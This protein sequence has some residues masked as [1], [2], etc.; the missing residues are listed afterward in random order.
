M[1]RFYI[2]PAATRTL[3]YCK[4]SAVLQRRI[5]RPM[6]YS[7]PIHGGLIVR[8][9]GAGERLLFFDTSF[10]RDLCLSDSGRAYDIQANISTSHEFKLH[11][12]AR[13]CLVLMNPNYPAQKIFLVN[14]KKLVNVKLR[15]KIPNI[16]ST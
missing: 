7:W 15:S 12:N 10:P 14:H 4:R 3:S 1:F 8:I 2:R 5:S 13:I 16:L 9:W 11:V 6:G